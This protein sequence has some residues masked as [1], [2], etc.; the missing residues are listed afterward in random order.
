MAH[1]FEPGAGQTPPGHRV[2]SVCVFVMP[3]KL[4]VDV[5]DVRLQRH[6]EVFIFSGR[7]RSCGIFLICFHFLISSVYQQGH[8][9]R[10]PVNHVEQEFDCGAE[11]RVLTG[12]DQAAFILVS[13]LTR[14]S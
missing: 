12:A 10:A 3:A 2:P 6:D 9:K 13:H 1:R 7:T 14:I 8:G 5:A 11:L 4:G